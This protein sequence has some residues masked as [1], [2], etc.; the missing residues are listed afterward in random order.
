MLRIII[1]LKV[2]LLR[3]YMF[4]DDYYEGINLFPITRI[5][6]TKRLAY[7]QSY[8]NDTKNYFTFNIACFEVE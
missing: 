6:A 1:C 4:V 7:L 3:T 5:E 8:L 2:F